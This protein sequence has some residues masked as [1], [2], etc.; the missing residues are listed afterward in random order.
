MNANGNG[1]G[2]TMEDTMVACGGG[3]GTEYY[4]ETFGDYL[5]IV[6]DGAGCAKCAAADEVAVEAKLDRGPLTHRPFEGLDQ[7]FD[8]AEQMAWEA[9]H[10][11]FD[12]PI[13]KCPYC[14]KRYCFC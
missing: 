3:C 11:D 5:F 7:W 6:Q 13:D 10:M 12:E 1:K 14:D 8:S 2:N 9:E 4:A